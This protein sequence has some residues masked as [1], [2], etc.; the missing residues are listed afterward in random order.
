MKFE[1]F[2]TEIDW[3]GNEQNGFKSRKENEQAW[4]VSIDEVIEKNFNLDIKN[5]YVAETVNHDPEELLA[6]YHQQQ[7]KLGI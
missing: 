2:K 6:E 5:P 1:E 3:Q 7:K 4:K